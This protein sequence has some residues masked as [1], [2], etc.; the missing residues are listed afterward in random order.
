MMP[1]SRLLEAF[2]TVWRRN[3]K[4]ST[5][6]IRQLTVYPL[7]PRVLLCETVHLR[8]RHVV[9][10]RARD[11]RGRVGTFAWLQP[12]VLPQLIN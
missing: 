8:S 9:Q 2:H 12:I 7:Y 5:S 11:S 6:A 1:K 10:L 4:L 3:D